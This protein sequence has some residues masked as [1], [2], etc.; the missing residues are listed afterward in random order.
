MG[1][2]GTEN[3]YFGDRSSLKNDVWSSADGREW[4]CE[5]PSAARAARAYHQAVAH[6]GRMYVFGGGNYVPEYSAMND[7]W[8]SEDGVNWQQETANAPG[9]RDSGS[10]QF[11]GEAACGC[12]EAGQKSSPQPRRCLVFTQWKGLANT[13]LRNNLEGA[14]RTLSVDLP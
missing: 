8:S 1:S 13:R 9:N 10:R 12:S 2:G 6:A 5:T 14:S 4:T 7:V 3:Y 11:P